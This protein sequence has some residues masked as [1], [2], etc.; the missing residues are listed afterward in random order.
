MMGAKPM[1]GA[2]Q[3]GSKVCTKPSCF[4]N[5]PSD[6]GASTTDM[7]VPNGRPNRVGSGAP[8]A[9]QR[10]LFLEPCNYQYIYIYIFRFIIV[11]YLYLS[12]HHE[13]PLLL[14]RFMALC[15]ILVVFYEH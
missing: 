14:C 4:V 5:L 13:L 1:Q 3:S 15:G 12:H 7:A 2:H 11:T 8:K 10:M 9:M 6:A